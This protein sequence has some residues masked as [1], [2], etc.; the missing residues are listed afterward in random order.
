M[1]SVKGFADVGH[2]VEAEVT[3]IVLC[4]SVTSCERARMCV[5]CWAGRLYEEG[6]KSTRGRS[7]SPSQ[8]LKLLA[9]NIG[10]TL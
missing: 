10:N 7:G 8:L 1:T 5:G 3:L 4:V 2:Q 9:G 6:I